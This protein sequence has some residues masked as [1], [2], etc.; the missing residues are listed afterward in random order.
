MATP[1]VTQRNL[2]KLPDGRYRVSD[3]LY[4]V[5]RRDG[6]SRSWV[7]RYQIGKTRKDLSLGSASAVSLA[8]AKD[9]VKKCQ[10]LLSRGIDPK[11][12]REEHRAQQKIDSLPR[13]AEYIGEV[14]EEIMFR[15]NV[16][17]ST[18]QCYEYYVKAIVDRFGDLYLSE[19]TPQLIHDKF[20]DYYGKNPNRA[21]SIIGLLRSVYAVAQRDGVI[22]TNPAIWDNGLDQYFQKFKTEDTVTHLYSATIQQTRSIVKKCLQRGTS[23][24]FA[25]ATI[26]FTASRQ[27]EISTL[28]WECVDF[29]NEV[30]SILPQF[31]KDGVNEVH[32]VPI[33]KQLVLILKHHY[34]FSEKKGPVFLGRLS[35]V[36]LAQHTVLAALKSISK[37]TQM[38]VHGFRS[39]FR[40][41]AA[42]HDVPFE[43]AEK[44]IM[45]KVGSVIYRSYQRSD[46]LEQRRE[47]MQ[48][49]ADT[50]ISVEIVEN[51]LQK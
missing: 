49:W 24:S 34:E 44:C 19:V 45:H 15:R 30:I 20:A 40:V 33:P 18:R 1:T 14:F 8:N 48:R 16:R 41:W 12:A 47:V 3:G 35:K 32:R 2:F 42:E 50:L 38:T 22:E 4:F 17:E 7:F 11:R 37:N 31:R 43:V 51:L 13:V 23:T 26:I 28:D 6:N 29:D 21:V 9:E 46:L 39:T 5:V 36:R 27:R 25:L 10:L